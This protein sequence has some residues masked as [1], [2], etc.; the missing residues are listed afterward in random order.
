LRFGKVFEEVL[1]I[2][3]D[4]VSSRFGYMLEAFRYGAPPH[5]GIAIGFDRLVAIL[6]GKRLASQNVPGISYSRRIESLED[7]RNE[8]VLVNAAIDALTPG[9]A[10]VTRSIV[11]AV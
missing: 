11:K 8:L 5:G 4:I 6:S 3:P 2:P 1:D 7:A 9:N 10:P